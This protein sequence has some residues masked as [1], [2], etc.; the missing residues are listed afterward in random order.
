MLEPLSPLLENVEE[1]MASVNQMDVRNITESV[2]DL[3]NPPH[4]FG[5]ETTDVE[6]ISSGT[7]AVEKT[8]IT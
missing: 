4:F 8:A 7:Y 6:N 2:V 5:I 3:D 1:S